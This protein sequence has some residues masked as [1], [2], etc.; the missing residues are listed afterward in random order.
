MIR[1]SLIQ[2][3]GLSSVLLLLGLF[4]GNVVFLLGAV[5]VLLVALLATALSP[6]SGIVVNRRLP[7]TAIWA[8]ETVPVHRSVTIHRGVGPVFVHENLPP[9]TRVDGGSNLRLVWKWP[10]MKTADLSYD[11]HFPKRGEFMLDE[12]KWETHAPFGTARSTVGH[13]GPSF[14]MTVI[15]RLRKVTRMSEVRAITKN[16]RYHDDIAQVGA[17]ST[18]FREI[19]PYVPGD[20]LKSI[21]WKAS[22]RG[23][24]G[25]GLPL[26]NELEPEARR[27][28]WLFLDIADYMDIG[29]PLLN[30]LESTIEASGSLT[31]YYLGR[32]STLGAFAYNS[33]SGQGELL[34]PESGRRQL[35]RLTKLMSSLKAGP[36]EQDVL[37]A[38]EWCRSFLL[39]LRPEVF[40]I[41]R[42]DVLYPRPGEAPDALDR[43]KDA[44]G[45]LT[46][47]RVRSRRPGRVRVVHVNAHERYP[48]P[49]GPGLARW[50]ARV[51]AS[52]IR[53]RGAAVIEWSPESEEFI[54]ALIRHMDAYR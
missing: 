26:V 51:V 39:R 31:Q 36:P 29:G 21:N 15:P 20:P 27:A 11:L 54:S 6:P 2:W 48:T 12:T 4:L 23:S 33:S 3:V 43:F 22:A 10:R 8:G 28:V 9:D 5:F 13:G 45:R 37:Q 25:D 40:I 49:E 42:L 38:V 7:R 50:E 24:R 34:S 53:T 30:P 18:E 17:S 19:R 44:I 35:H 46:A 32:G 41:T 47:L 14:E 1:F 52:E 16:T